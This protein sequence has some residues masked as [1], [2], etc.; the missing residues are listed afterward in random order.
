MIFA[1]TDKN[2]SA[3]KTYTEIWDEIKQEIELISGNKVNRY[4]KDFIGIKFES[5]DDLPLSEIINIPVCAVV[6]TSVFEEDGKYYP[7]ILLYD[8]FYEYKKCRIHQLC[9]ALI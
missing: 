8:C 1:R 6:I 4:S 7:Q 3:L 9:K 5:D 2:K